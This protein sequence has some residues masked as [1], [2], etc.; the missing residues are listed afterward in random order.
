M[1]HK[2]VITLCKGESNMATYTVDLSPSLVNLG[3]EGSLDTV[4]DTNGNSLQ[5]TFFGVMVVNG[6][7]SKVVGNVRDGGT[8]TD[9]VAGISDYPNLS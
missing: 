8:F 5:R 4:K 2:Y 1:I 9:V 7:N 6:S 3:T